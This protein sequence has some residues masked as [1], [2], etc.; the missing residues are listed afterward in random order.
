M[1]QHHSSS[2]AESVDATTLG[3]LDGLRA[4]AVSLV[5]FSHYGPSLVPGAYGVVLFFVLSGFLITRLLL[6][7][8]RLSG[9][10]SLKRFY[11]R[12]S[13]RI[14][15]AFYV[16]WFGAAGWTKIPV[17]GS[18]LPYKQTPMPYGYVP[19]VDAQALYWVE[20]GVNGISTKLWKRAK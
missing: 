18:L 8:Q 20:G 5:V 7:E 17:D 15:P 13:L 12:R 19:V 16:Y 9:G 10:I 4:L 14:F 2:L 11:A 1:T 3:G 6:R